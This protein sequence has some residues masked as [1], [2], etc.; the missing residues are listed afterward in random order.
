MLKKIL[1]LIPFLIPLKEYGLEMPSVFSDNMILQRDVPAAVWGNGRPGETIT[2]EFNGQKLS[3]TVRPDTNW[4]IF[5]AP[6]K[7]DAKGRSLVVTGETKLTFQNVLVG[8]VWLCA[9]QS[10]MQF[11]LF[12][13]REGKEAAASADRRIRLL[14]IP[15]SWSRKPEYNIEAVWNEATPQTLWYFSGFAYFFGRR[16]FQETGVPQGLVNISWGGARIESML[17]RT[18]LPL[19]RIRD[20]VRKDLENQFHDLDIRSDRE[21]RV[22]KQRLPGVLFHKMIRPLS[23]MAVRGVIWY[24]GED[25]H[26][27]GMNYADKL[28]VLSETFR[29]S[30]SNPRL[31]FYLIQ[32]PPYRYSLRDPQ[33]LP[34]FW[35]AQFSWASRDSN[36]AV[37][38]STDCGDFKDIHPRHKRRLAERLADTV[39]FREY[40][41]GSPAVLSPRFR[42]AVWKNDKIIVSFHNASGLRSRDGKPISFLSIAG[43]DR[44]FVK[45]D[46]WIQE[47]TLIL[48]VKAGMVP[49]WIRLGWDQSGNHNLV[50]CLG[51]PAEP[52]EEEIQK[53]F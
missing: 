6:M 22:D 36:A 52:F 12:A 35:K 45:S 3:T 40:G 38:V 48:P 39:L 21:L 10:N 34:R 44:Y 15:R 20:A 27:D 41:K 23:P 30:F 4:R 14:Q 47:D 17:D 7:A 11:A 49:K 5:L 46:G 51:V 25:N 9:G 24:Q 33:L 13:V 16:L 50:N 29:R 28:Q 31:P 42:S 18:V 43:A 19:V 26:A 53:A 2:V 37:I 8:D 32:I 1:L